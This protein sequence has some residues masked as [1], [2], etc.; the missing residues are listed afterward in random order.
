VFGGLINGSGSTGIMAALQQLATTDFLVVVE[1]AQHKGIW[2]HV[3]FY[4]WRCRRDH[5]RRRGVGGRGRCGAYKHCGRKI[6][7]FVIAFLET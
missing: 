1:G 7:S 3:V 6:C 5:H 4:A 2:V